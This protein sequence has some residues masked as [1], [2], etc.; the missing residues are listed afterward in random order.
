MKKRSMIFWSILAFGLPMIG[1]LTFGQGEMSVPE[2]VQKIFRANCS[3]IGCHQGQYPPMNISFEPD[4]IVPSTVN[5][6]SREKPDLRIIDT[7]EPAKSYLLMKIRGDRAIEGKRMP[8]NATPLRDA[9][10]QAIQE[11]ILSLRGTGVT[12]L[13][14]SALGEKEQER[15]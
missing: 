15:I 10:I 4:K 9:D 7:A 5:A 2:P 3:T 6:P 11:W 1:L 13:T 14:D 12:A 8:L